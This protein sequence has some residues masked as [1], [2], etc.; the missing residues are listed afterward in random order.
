MLMDGVCGRVWSRNDDVMSRCVVERS[1]PPTF[2]PPVLQISVEP[3]RG[4]LPPL[5]SCTVNVV[6][7]PRFSQNFD[8]ELQFSVAD[9]SEL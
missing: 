9:G 1:D 3:C 8:T 4:M 6:F 7:W 5:A 2:C